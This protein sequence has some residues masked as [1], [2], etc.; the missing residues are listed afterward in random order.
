MGPTISSSMEGQG[1]S[2]LAS[3]WFE[4]WAP[5]ALRQSAMDTHW[6]RHGVDYG[7]L[8]ASYRKAQCNQPLRDVQP[9]WGSGRETGAARPAGRQRDRKSKSKTNGH[10]V[11]SPVIY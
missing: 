11:R 3:P 10:I 7:A 6:A 4:S 1:V 2:A 8:Q 5:Q 9:G